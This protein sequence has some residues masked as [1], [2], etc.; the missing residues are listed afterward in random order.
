MGYYGEGTDQTDRSNVIQIE[1]LNLNYP[2]PDSWFNSTNS[3]FNSSLRSVFSNLNQVGCLTWSQLLAKNNN[4]PGTAESD[5]QNC[6]ELNAA[7]P[8]FD[9]GLLQMNQ[10]GSFYFMSTRNNVFSNINQKG[11]LTVH[12]TSFVITTGVSGPVTSTSSSQTS[13]SSGVSTSATSSSSLN[14]GAI[15]VINIIL[16]YAMIIL[17]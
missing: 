15:V 14:S 9:G 11:S 4:N 13:T 12:D 5:V 7:S 17:C 6:M 10:I 2:A 3:L 8:Y 16:L 1:A